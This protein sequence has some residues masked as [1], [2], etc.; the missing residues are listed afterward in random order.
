M[1]V[2]IA[3]DEYLVRAS[4]KS[5]IQELDI[6]V[7]IAGEASNGEE[8]VRLV[9]DHNPDIAFVDIRM[10]KLNGLEA[11]K[12]ARNN[13]PNTQW[14]ILT[15][16]SEFDYAKESIRLGASGYLLK[17]ASPEELREV[18]DNQLKRTRETISILNKDF[19][20]ELIALAND[21]ST[22]SDD[23]G[24][25][26]ISKARFLCSI[27]IFDS[28]L[29]E[30]R[31]SELHMKFYKAVRSMIN[32]SSTTDVRIALFPMPNGELATVGAWDPKNSEQARNVIKIYF[33]EITAAVREFSADRFSI[34]LLQSDEC[35]SLE[36]LHKR[37]YQLQNLSPLRT[38][39]SCS[40]RY[41][42]EELAQLYKTEPS[43][44]LEL[45]NL[46]IKLAA[47]YREKAYLN[48]IKTLEDIEK[49][50]LSS[51]LSDCSIIKTM[52]EFLLNTVNCRIDTDMEPK[53]WMKTLRE[54][55]EVLLAE[56]L[57]EDNQAPDAVSQVIAFID[58]SYMLD[59]SIG[60][61]AE[62]LNITPNYLS[63]LFHKKTGTTFMK[64]LTKVRML[65]A[66]ELLANPGM[67]VQ[68]AAEKVGYYSTRHFTKLFKEFYGYYPSECRGR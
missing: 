47:A 36:M 52:A 7:D 25:G 10:P 44:V 61:I 17:P 18:F 63:S 54:H 14:I 39:N 33:E 45:S 4:L 13:S 27:F 8:M 40:R 62:Q 51:K 37:M 57:K 53:T 68:Q 29:N 48:Y 67:Q 59:I 58:G 56:S 19:E 41:T 1:K 43:E 3:D 65:K 24:P 2:I 22:I 34:T 35:S 49:I 60:Q 55:G 32:D 16:F 9:K 21:L 20:N 11:I 5:M 6:P 26:F 30:N 46:L 31:K 28:C 66:K 15:G 38:V 42:I 12:I 64:Y 50:I 23:A